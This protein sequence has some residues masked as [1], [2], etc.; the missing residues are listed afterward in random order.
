MGK[1]VRANRK[2]LLGL[3]QVALSLVLLVWLLSRVG[4]AEVASTLA[5]LH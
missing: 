5:S 2:K 4:L 3:S 1:F